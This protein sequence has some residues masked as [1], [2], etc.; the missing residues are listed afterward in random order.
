MDAAKKTE[1]NKGPL[2]SAP[3]GP[4]LNSDIEKFQSLYRSELGIELSDEAAYEKGMKLLRLMS[5]VYKPMT[6]EEYANIEDHRHHTKSL[7]TNEFE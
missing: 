4:L 3:R 1:F 6:K 7:L 5:L 2:V